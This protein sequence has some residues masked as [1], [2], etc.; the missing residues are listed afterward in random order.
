MRLILLFAILVLDTV[1]LPAVGFSQEPKGAQKEKKALESTLDVGDVRIGATSAASVVFRGGDRELKAVLIYP[2]D[3]TSPSH[4]PGRYY[5]TPLWAMVERAKPIEGFPSI[6]QDVDGITEDGTV[7]LTFRVKLGTPELFQQCK[8]AVLEQDWKNA[9]ANGRTKGDIVVRPWPLTHAVITCLNVTTRDIL[10]VCETGTLT[11]KTEDLEFAMPFTAADLHKFQ[12]AVQRGKLAFVYAST[13]IGRQVYEGQVTVRGGK[14]IQLLA[15]EILSSNQVNGK[16]PIF[17]AQKNEVSRL[18]LVSLQKTM[19]VQHKDLLPL[20]NTT[21]MAS[22]LFAPENNLSQADLAKD[23][24]AAKAVAAY[25]IPVLTKIQET[26][27]KQD[28]KVATK[29]EVEKQNKLPADG[30][31]FGIVSVHRDQP[32]QVNESLNRIQQTTGA[33]YQRIEETN[34]Y[35]PHSIK[36]WKFRSGIDKMEFNETNTVFL[37]VGRSNK[38]LV[39]AE[40]SAA[41]TLGV[42]EKGGVVKGEGG[43]LMEIEA[44]LIKDVAAAEKKLS[45]AVAASEKIVTTKKAEEERLTLLTQRVADA[46]RRG[47]E[48]QARLNEGLK[49]ADFLFRTAIPRTDAI[50]ERIEAAFK[51]PDLRKTVDQGKDDVAHWEAEVAEQKAKLRGTQ[52]RFETADKTVRECNDKLVHVRAELTVVRKRI[53]I[54]P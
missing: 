16:A 11:G 29:E 40:V 44:G 21:D 28:I 52:A 42:A 34:Y 31:S 33:T 38:Y 6:V 1:Y 3:N 13:Y 19:I 2:E 15:S 20:L 8:K 25:L 10:S 30:F 41:F 54:Q 26:T 45:D 32:L 51:V 49:N 4:V 18:A 23:S 22:R 35:Q 5:H 17:Q 47:E 48:A 46:K 9:L 24:E 14:D 43:L 50:R 7:F 53:E 37:A 12:V 39:E 36:V 27:G